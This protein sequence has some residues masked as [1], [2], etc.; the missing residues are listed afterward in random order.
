MRPRDPA[1]TGHGCPQARGGTQR[2]IQRREA[3]PRERPRAPRGR[4]GAGR[5][6]EL[7]PPTEGGGAATGMERA[8][9]RQHAAAAAAAAPR[10][11]GGLR[12]FGSRDG[13]VSAGPGRGGF[14]FSCRG[15]HLLAGRGRG[16][17]F[18]VPVRGGRAPLAEGC[19]PSTP[20]QD[21]LGSGEGSFFGWWGKSPLSIRVGRLIAPGCGRGLSVEAPQ[22]CV[23]IAGTARAEDGRQRAL[24]WAVTP[25]RDSSWG[26]DRHRATEELRYVGPPKPGCC[27]HGTHHT[28]PMKRCKLCR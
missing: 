13:R 21:A 25:D 26:R 16:K 12:G 10:R 8:G 15:L 11:R 9:R 23:P 22:L 6:R 2:R 28:D 17:G 24:L 18:V 27:C 1:H 14:A 5:C 3:G 7:P 19:L 4:A 20:Q